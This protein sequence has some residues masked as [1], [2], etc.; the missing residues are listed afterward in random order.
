MIFPLVSLTVTQ[1][2][3][4]QHWA[5]I[6]QPTST[7]TLGDGRTPSGVQAGVVVV[8]GSPVVVVAGSPVVVV[9]ITHAPVIGSQ[10]PASHPVM[11]Q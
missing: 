4:L 5:L 3:S 10:K 9:G 2:R 6:W 8:G 11:M 7:V 1:V